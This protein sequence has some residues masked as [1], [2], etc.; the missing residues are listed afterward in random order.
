MLKGRG[1]LAVAPALSCSGGE[2]E[3]LSPRKD[4]AEPGWRGWGGSR[5]LERAA[6]PRP[7]PSKAVSWL[8]GWEQQATGFAL[9]RARSVFPDGA[10]TGRELWQGTGL[11]L[12][13]LPWQRKDTALT[14]VFFVK[15]DRFLLKPKTGCALN[16][17]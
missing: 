2:P 11:H 13:R 1:A 5:G 4:G 9:D 10:G 15:S 16:L 6:P 8:A 7:A 14:L 3:C 17:S 12:F